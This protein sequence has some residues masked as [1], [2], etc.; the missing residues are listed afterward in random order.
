MLCVESDDDDD[1]LLDDEDEPELETVLIQHNGAINRIRVCIVHILHVIMSTC[2]I[3]LCPH[4]ACRLHVIHM[5]T[6]VCHI[7]VRICHV[8][9]LFT[10]HC[11]SS[12][13]YLHVHAI[14]MCM[15]STCTC[16]CHSHMCMSFSHVHVVYMCMLS[17]CACCLHVHVNVIFTCACR[18]CFI[19]SSQDG[20]PHCGH[21]VRKGCG[22]HLGC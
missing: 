6:C 4:V 14:C 8:H 7:H 11:V 20:T 15:F 3:S 1:E 16:A 21:M 2:C 19:G 5:S 22:Q 17:T 18:P 10:C 9:M 13:C 12:A